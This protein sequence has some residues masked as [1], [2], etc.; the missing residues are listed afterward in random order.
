MR[1]VLFLAPMIVCFSINASAGPDDLS[2]GPDDLD[3]VAQTDQAADDNNR[4]EN[5][6]RRPRE[7]ARGWKAG[8]IPDETMCPNSEERR[9][10]ICKS[11]PNITKL[12][13][14]IEDE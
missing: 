2:A 13:D 5:A 12:G 10:W 9:I 6:A 8:S 11:N 1:P 4:C 14:C 3:V 7:G